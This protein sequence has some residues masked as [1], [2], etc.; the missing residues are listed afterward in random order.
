GKIAF[1]NLQKAILATEAA[2]KQT[3]EFESKAA[4]ADLRANYDQIRSEMQK[5][6]S[7]FEKNGSTWS[8]ERKNEVA[9]QMEYKRADLELVTKKLQSENQA[10]L[11]GIIQANLQR[12]SKIA[13]ELIESEGIGLVLN[14]E[15]V[16][17]A[18]SSFDY[19]A[20]ITDR[21]N[22]AK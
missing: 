18:D 13:Q 7:E 17:Y 16:A 5:L 8:E 11:Q 10:L 19:T 14:A 21:L 20:K 12:A 3:Q 15:A 9:K 6:N 2:Q 4:Y 22:K 1:F